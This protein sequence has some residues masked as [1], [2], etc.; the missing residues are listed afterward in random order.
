MKCIVSLLGR[1]AAD[2]ELVQ[3]PDG[4]R[5][6]VL[7]VTTE[8]TWTDEGGARRSRPTT[9]RVVVRQ[10]GRAKA[11]ARDLRAGDLVDVTG[12]L[13]YPSSIPGAPDQ[14]EIQIRAAFHTLLFVDARAGLDA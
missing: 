7:A 8:E 13:A 12:T 11:A 10:S 9:H 1:L 3:L 2:P 4:R 6:A 5:V 14:L